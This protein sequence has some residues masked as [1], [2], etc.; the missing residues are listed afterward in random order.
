MKFYYNVAYFI[1]MV[2]PTFLP[3]LFC[4]DYWTVCL[5]IVTHALIH[6]FCFSRET[7][8]GLFRCNHTVNYLYKDIS[9][10]YGCVVDLAHILMT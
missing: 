9:R 2:V 10:L 3:Y 8:T 7:I 5:Q 1:E 4:F 6:T